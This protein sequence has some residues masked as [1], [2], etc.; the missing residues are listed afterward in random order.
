MEKNLMDFIRTL[1]EKDTKS[2]IAKA[3]KT[4]EEV[5]ELAKAILPFENAAGT[6]HRFSDKEKVL[7]SAADVILCALSIAHHLKFSDD[8]IEE[9]LHKKSKKWSEIQTKESGVKHPLPYEIHITVQRPDNMLVFKMVCEELKVKPIV[10]DLEKDETVIMQ[11]V[12]TSSIHYGDN[13]TAYDTAM[14]LRYELSMKGYSVMRV[15]IETVPWHPA[16]PSRDDDHFVM[17]PDSYF[18][19]HLR[20]VTTEGR[21][22]ELKKIAKNQSAHLSRN[23]Y[24]KISETEYVIMMTLRS[25]TDTKDSFKEKVDRLKDLLDY[26]KFLVDKIEVEFAVYDTK[27]THDKAWIDG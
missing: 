19:S 9:M 13:R 2:L 20:I 12:M 3:C 5:G 16:A 26:H 18:E 15:K 6:L 24:K 8:E 25:Q 10:I 17:P 27:V 23:F 21:V 22:G 11:D 14:S 4:S 1:S 7:D